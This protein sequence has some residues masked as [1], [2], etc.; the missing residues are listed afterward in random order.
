MAENGT[1]YFGNEDGAF[2]ALDIGTRQVLWTF[3]A[4]GAIETRPVLTDGKIIFNV[5][6]SLY[7]LNAVTGEPI[8]TLTYPS[9]HSERVSDDDFAF[10][11]SQVAV[12]D[13]VAYFAA[14][15]GDLVAV[16]ILSGEIIWTLVAPL[17]GLVSSGVSYYAG[18]LYFIGFPG[19][20]YAVDIHTGQTLFE[21]QIRNMAFKPMAIYDGMMYIGGRNMRFYCIDAA[22]GEVIWRSHSQNPGTWFSGGSV[23]IGSSVFTGTADENRITVFDKD[24]GEFERSYPALGFVYTPL[25]SHGNNVIALTTNIFAA[26]DDPRLTAERRI[27]R[28]QAFSIDTENHTK[29][30]LA[31]LDT[32][33]VSAPIIYQDI[34]YFGSDSGR[35]YSIDLDIS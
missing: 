20:L 3:A 8:H 16:D 2:H 10:N 23:I 24:S 22:S 13:G 26:L 12:T 32:T 27:P 21:T 17:E 33:V 19:N 7:I 30:W 31:S 14:L 34:L 15:N 6:N 28:S 29:I 25:L 5:G 35:V 18:K 11:D 9:T 1:L 4:S